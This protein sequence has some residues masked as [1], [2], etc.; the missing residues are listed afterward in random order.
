MSRKL[1]GLLVVLALAFAASAHAESVTV[2]EGDYYF[3]V[4]GEYQYLQRAGN[5]GTELTLGSVGTLFG[6]V[7]NGD[8]TFHLESADS[9]AAG[10]TYYYVTGPTSAYCDASS[11]AASWSLE[12]VG[13]G[14]YYIV[15][16]NGNYLTGAYYEDSS[17]GYGYYYI[18]E[19][20]SDA[21]AFELLSRAEYIESLSARLDDQAATAAEAAGLSAASVEELEAAVAEADYQAI[22]VELSYDDFSAIYTNPNAYVA[23]TISDPT[24]EVYNGT[25][26]AEQTLSDLSAGL[27][28]VEVN[29]M[30]RTF[31]QSAYYTYDEDSTIVANGL[32]DV[33][34]DAAYI[35]A[36]DAIDQT[37]FYGDYEG[38]L[39]INSISTFTAAAE[40]GAY[41]KVL[42]VYVEEGEDLTI[43][44]ATPYRTNY[45]APWTITANWTVSKLAAP[46]YADLALTASDPA[47]TLDD[48]E[49]NPADTLT[50]LGEFY[51]TIDSEDITAYV[52]QDDDYNAAKL[53]EITAYIKG[54]QTTYEVSDFWAV[55]GA[56]N[57][58]GLQVDGDIEEEG[59]LVISFPE[60]AVG[61][62]DAW[63]SQGESGHV[64]AA[65]AFYYWVGS[66]A[67]EETSIEL[68]SV[69]A[70]G[71]TVGSLSTFE[72]YVGNDSTTEVYA[73]WNVNPVLYDADGNV[74]E[75]ININKYAE[76]SGLAS[77]GGWWYDHYWVTLTLTESVVRA[78]TYTL[79]LPSGT[80]EVG[81]ETYEEEV[82]FTYIVDGSEAPAYFITADPE[83]GSTVKSLSTVSVTFDDYTTVTT[84]SA[85]Y[86]YTDEELTT[87][88]TKENGYTNYASASASGNTIT[89]TMAEAI[90]TEGTYYVVIKASKTTVDGESLTEDV[91]L[92]YYVEPLPE[93]ITVDPADESTVE[94]LSTITITWD[95]YGAISKRSG[96]VYVYDADGNYVCYSSVA[97]DGNTATVSLSKTVTDEGDY[98]VKVP[99]GYVYLLENTDSEID[100][101]VYS[102]AF[103]LNYTV[104]AASGDEDGDSE[105]CTITGITLVEGESY[106]GLSADATVQFEITPADEVGY[107]FYKVGTTE[108]G[109]DLISRTTLTYNEET[110]YFEATV[111]NDVTFSEEAIYVTVYAYATENDYN[112]DND[113]LASITYVIS[114]AAEASELSSVTLTSVYPTNGSDIET[115]DDLSVLL[116]FSGK[117]NINSETSFLNYGQGITYSFSSITGDSSTTGEDGLEYSDYWTLV[118]DQSYFSVFEDGLTLTIVATDENGARVYDED[119]SANELPDY[120][121]LSL[122]YYYEGET[123][124]LSAD[125]LTI[126]SSD[127][128]VTISSN[129]GSSLGLGSGS[130]K[131]YDA[132]GNLV[133]SGL[134]PASNFDWDT[135]TGGDTYTYTLEGLTA[136]V[137]YTLVIPAGAIT[138]ESGEGYEEITVEVTVSE[139]DDS[140]YTVVLT[141]EGAVEQ[142]VDTSYGTV[143][144]DFDSSAILAALGAESMDDVTFA[145]VVDGEYITTYTAN[146]GYYFNSSVEVCNWAADACAFFTEFYGAGY[147]YIAL[148]QYPG[149]VAVGDSFTVTLAFLYDGNAVQITLTYTIV[150]TTGISAINS[151]SSFDATA[152]YSIGGQLVRTQAT[153]LEGLPQGIYIVNG[154][155]VLVK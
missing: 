84:G 126:T 119:L 44:F 53:G 131:L 66:A 8:G 138:N 72:I 40:E 99:S 104:E 127:S 12:A 57:T 62:Y 115:D 64:N 117:V 91:V 35:Y 17:L 147:D 136:G 67:E 30:S 109:A 118:V 120:T 111:Y 48:E 89:L 100:Y 148:G 41:A 121:Y 70:N 59:W 130:A 79:V 113:P 82:S 47:E 123:E 42:Y 13:D 69:P 63:A 149:G 128:I 81:G 145:T 31:L 87:M 83:D 140:G 139:G 137:T 21:P 27:Y 55:R 26:G 20:T 23:A 93:G 3:K 95:N 86:V 110:G 39:D 19:T 71:E 75:E 134:D 101:D 151:D 94:S 37:A 77:D 14:T 15:N 129:D 125:E 16:S 56:T 88:A 50:A 124:Y 85:I 90:A 97:I 65:Q 2:E 24:I 141:L 32:A 29:A 58:F 38:Y 78:G 144:Y 11:G 4:S 33:S 105:E 68:N 108:G 22:E 10:C 34:S 116:A 43:G 133:Q 155:K 106:E 25:G 98:V 80:L 153:S 122:E 142:E 1:H 60:G 150:D 6:L 54:S 74:V 154:K 36:N 132:E 146:Y 18:G 73:T 107:A 103:N 49:G 5:W 7:D 52:I 143:T 76:N 112:Y 152:I 51:F 28:K 45:H 61:D 46:L 102:S 135:W 9:K 92:T 96:S 114:G